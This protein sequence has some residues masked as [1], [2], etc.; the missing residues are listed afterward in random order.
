MR[1]LPYSGREWAEEVSYYCILSFLEERV[2]SQSKSQV[3]P[4]QAKSGQVK[5]SGRLFPLH[6]AV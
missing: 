6:I 4:S 2:P 3:K 1:T 5:W